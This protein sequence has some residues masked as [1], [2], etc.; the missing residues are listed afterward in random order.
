[1][2]SLL[3]LFGL[4]LEDK[5]SCFVDEGLVSFLWNLVLLYPYNDILHVLIKKIFLGILECP[6]VR[7]IFF[8]NY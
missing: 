8:K 4:V 2:Y 3:V 6:D 5:I 1:M 7:N